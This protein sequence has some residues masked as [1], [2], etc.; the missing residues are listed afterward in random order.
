VSRR[1][2]ARHGRGKPVFSFEFFPPKTDEGAE[3]LLRTLADLRDAH[4][5]DFVSVTYGAG[6]STRDRTIELV[7]RIQRELQ[8]AALDANYPLAAREWTLA[9]QATPGYRPSALSVLGQIA[10]AD[11]PA[12]L[13]ALRAHGSPQADR[14]AAGL[15][16]RWG[17]PLGAV[18]RLLASAGARGSEQ[19]AMLQELFDDLRGTATRD[20][21]HARGILLEAMA[22][23]EQGAHRRQRRRQSR[24]G[25]A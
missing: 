23:R 12:L 7:T 8:I 11:R 17:D 16:A 15:M 9:L 5:P 18:R 10:P 13:E 25:G 19:G 2:G 14:L 1:I 4:D 6:G 24:S 3:N 22:E 20:L 21:N